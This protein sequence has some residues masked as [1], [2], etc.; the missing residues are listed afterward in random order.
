[1]DP[2]NYGSIPDAL[3][4]RYMHG[5]DWSHGSGQ[6]HSCV[7]AFPI[8]VEVALMINSGPGPNPYPFQCPLLHNAYDNAWVAN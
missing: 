8:T 1:M 2:A 5:G 6:L 4:V 7:V 3:G